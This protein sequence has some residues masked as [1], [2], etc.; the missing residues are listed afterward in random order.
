MKVFFDTE[1]IEDGVTIDL[2]SIG[3][4]TE[5]GRTFT[6]ASTEADLSRAT[7]WVRAHVLPLLPPKGDPAWMSRIEIHD[8]L[9]AF[10]GTDTPEFWGYCADYDWVALCQLFGRMLDL[11]RGWPKYAHDLR[12][13][14]DEHG[15]TRADYPVQDP[16]SAHD[17]LADAR[18]NLE[19]WKT[20]AAHS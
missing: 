12:Q 8:A 19:L 10:I 15:L 20:I 3:L 1:F 16:A 17:A 18:W 6:V 13:A 2:I 7:S 4:V 9:I 11:P 5:D 14:A